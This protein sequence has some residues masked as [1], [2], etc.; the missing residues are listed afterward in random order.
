MR[1]S[2]TSGSVRGACDETHV[3]TAT[4][5]CCFEPEDGAVSAHFDKGVLY[6]TGMAH[7]QSAKLRAARTEKRVIDDEQRAG[8]DLFQ[9]RE[10]RIDFAV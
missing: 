1:E 5:L 3:P 6:L 10:H 4:Q 8:A 2:R 7:C 9:A